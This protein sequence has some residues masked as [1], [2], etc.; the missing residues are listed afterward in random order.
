MVIHDMRNPANAAE[1]GMTITI[2]II[3][4]CK[5]LYKQFKVRVK[6][7]KKQEAEKVSF[8][9]FNE[10]QEFS[11]HVNSDEASLDYNRINSL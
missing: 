11:S 7:M 4:E 2:D 9:E 1:Y 3:N 10:S 6:N 8:E 5:K